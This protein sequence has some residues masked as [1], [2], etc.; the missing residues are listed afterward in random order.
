MR[1]LQCTQ[2]ALTSRFLQQ[3]TLLVAASS[4]PARCLKCVCLLLPLP[5]GP[6]CISKND[7]YFS[8]DITVESRWLILN[9][10]LFPDPQYGKQ[11]KAV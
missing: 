5:A 2:L 10:T 9:T 4:S 7:T 11:C 6:C 8:M 3:F 1:Q